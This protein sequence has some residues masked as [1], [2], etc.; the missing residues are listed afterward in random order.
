[1]KAYAEE[2]GDYWH[3]VATRNIDKG[4]YVPSFLCLRKPSKCD[5]RATGMPNDELYCV[6]VVKFQMVD[7]NLDVFKVIR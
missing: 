4:R 2:S 5:D 6:S 7:D 3:P 1:M